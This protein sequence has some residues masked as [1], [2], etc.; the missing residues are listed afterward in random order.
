MKS[1]FKYFSLLLLLP[2]AV[3]AQSDPSTKSS[4]SSLGLKDF[5]KSAPIYVKS[6]K[7]HLDTKERVFVYSGKV[8]IVRDELFI[9]SNTSTGRYDEKNK[10]KRIVC[11]DNVVI[12]R[13]E[14][15]RATSEHA[16]YLVPEG[17]IVLTE[18]PEL[19]HQGNYLSAD[20]ITIFIEEDRSEAEGNVKVRVVTAEENIDDQ[21]KF[22]NSNT[23]IDR[24]DPRWK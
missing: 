24:N 18:A 23:T 14:G 6:Q 11:D 21:N 3:I 16:E 2:T 13:G 1:Y 4:V 17:Q 22:L 20:K 19:Y 15:L 10:L 12:T 8:E 5:D 9:T 7:L